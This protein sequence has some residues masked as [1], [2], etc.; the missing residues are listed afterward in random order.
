MGASETHQHRFSSSSQVSEPA[1]KEK[2]GGY[3]GW[4]REVFSEEKIRERKESLKD[5]LKRGYVNDFKELRANQ[6]KVF[7]ASDSL[8]GSE[9]SKPFP[10]LPFVNRE[11]KPAQV[12]VVAADDGSVKATLVCIAFRNGAEEMLLSWSDPFKSQFA[13]DSSTRVC[14][15]SLVDSALMGSWPFRGM[16]LRGA[17]PVRAAPTSPGDSLPIMHP[18]TDYVFHF[19]E[20]REA[21][22]ALGI[23]NMLTG[24]VFLLDSRGRVRWRGSGM[25]E[26]WEVDALLRCSMQLVGDSKQ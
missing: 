5:E 20:T 22:K 4:L 24:Y 11:D 26:Q 8:W 9:A 15:L 7:A 23:T 18:S 14:E 10:A 6:G 13:G 12:P 17:G 19:G 1:A 25:S 21:R 3:F 16:I 2:K